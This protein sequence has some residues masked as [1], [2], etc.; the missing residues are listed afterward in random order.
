MSESL[1]QHQIDLL[2]DAVDGE[3]TTRSRVLDGLLDLRLGAADLPGVVGRIDDALADLPGVT[4]VPNSWWLATLEDL[5][6][7]LASTAVSAG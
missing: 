4:T 2:L 3:L 7:V 5:R 6:T 1:L